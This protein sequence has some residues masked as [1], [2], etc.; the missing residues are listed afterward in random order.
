ICHPPDLREDTRRDRDL[1]RQ[2]RGSEELRLYAPYRRNAERLALGLSADARHSRSARCTVAVSAR[3]AVMVEDRT[4][5][6]VVWHFR[7]QL[8]AWREAAS[9][10]YVLA[11][12]RHDRGKSVA[13]GELMAIDAGGRVRRQRIGHVELVEEHGRILRIRLGLEQPLALHC[14]SI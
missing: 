12:P 7:P 11:G 10:G 14:R 9:C 1:L 8:T 3:R 2:F 5:H 13:K 4:E 6:G